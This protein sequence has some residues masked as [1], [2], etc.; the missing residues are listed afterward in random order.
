MKV[1][2]SVKIIIR[3]SEK[4]IF[5]NKVLTKMYSCNVKLLFKIFKYSTIHYKKFRF[6]SIKRD[7]SNIKH[8]IVLLYKK[9]NT[10]KIR[11]DITRTSW[12][13]WSLTWTLAWSRP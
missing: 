13:S 6:K 5:I 9:H 8:G 3:N 2:Y 4:L 10:L 12:T 7:K 11:T 1:F